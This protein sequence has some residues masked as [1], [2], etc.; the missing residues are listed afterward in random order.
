M[1]ARA[2]SG[3]SS[4]VRWLKVLLPL[5][6]VALIAAIFLSPQGGSGSL[7]PAEVARLA[8]GLQVENPVFKGTTDD[9]EPFEVTATVAVPDGPMAN[10]IALEDPVGLVVSNDNGL[11]TARA[12]RGVF[13]RIDDTLILEGS[14]RE[15]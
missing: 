15:L 5:M 3:Y 7:P 2:R 6:A 8:A 14:V 10:E 12:D 4:L 13:G 11:V 9:G 1:A